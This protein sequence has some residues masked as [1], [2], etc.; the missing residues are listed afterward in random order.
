MVLVWTSIVD[1]ARSIK[2]V[3]AAKQQKLLSQ[4][5]NTA[6]FVLMVFVLPLTYK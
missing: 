6:T 3:D 5:V 4:I 1:T 2:K